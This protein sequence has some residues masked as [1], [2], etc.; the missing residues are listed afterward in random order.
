MGHPNVLSVLRNLWVLAPVTRNR[1]HSTA[2]EETES[3]GTSVGTNAEDKSPPRNSGLLSR[4]G[5]PK[6]VSQE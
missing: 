5:T 3:F 1:W 6:N 2:K 4:L